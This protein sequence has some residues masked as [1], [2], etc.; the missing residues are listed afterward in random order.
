MRRRV[1]LVAGRRP[2]G[3]R[4][5]GRTLDTA[6]VSQVARTVE[7]SIL[8]S[9]LEQ[10]E[11]QIGTNLLALTSLTGQAADIARRRGRHPIASPRLTHCQIEEKDVTNA[12]LIIGVAT[13][14]VF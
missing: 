13:T 8:G 7:T 4:D 3:V 5:N 1:S 9:D 12:L 6:A 14:L 10:W 11:R 2:F